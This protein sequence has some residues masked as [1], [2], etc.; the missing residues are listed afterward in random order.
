MGASSDEM[1]SIKNTLQ[2]WRP[3][4]HGIPAHRDANPC[5]AI[6]VRAVCIGFPNLLRSRSPWTRVVINIY[7]KFKQTHVVLKVRSILHGKVICTH[8]S[9][10]KVVVLASRDAEP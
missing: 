3:S 5:S 4:L 1:K 7:R 10:V 6:S 8:E 2:H 9:V